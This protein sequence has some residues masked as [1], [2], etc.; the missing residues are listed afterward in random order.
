LEWLEHRSR[1]GCTPAET[2]SPID[3][4][5]SI[6]VTGNRPAGCF[7]GIRTFDLCVTQFSNLMSKDETCLQSRDVVAEEACIL[8]RRKESRRFQT[9]TYR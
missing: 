9:E 3:P 1:A 8:D 6:Y 5:D 7:W 4:T 2:E